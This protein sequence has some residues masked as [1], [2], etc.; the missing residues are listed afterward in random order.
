MKILF[1]GLGSIG[2]RHLRLIQQHFP[3]METWAHRTHLGQNSFEDPDI[4]LVF[5]W[6]GIDYL[7]PDIAFI[8]NPP[9]LHISTAIKCAKRGMHLFIEKP[10]GHNTDG[11]D[12]LLK[13]CDQ[14]GLTAYVAYPLRFHPT[15]QHLQAIVENN[16]PL[17]ARI[18]CTS[19]L[20]GWRPGRNHLESYSA[21]ENMGGGALLDVSHEIYYAEW[22]FG[23][24][25]EIQGTRGRVAD[26]ITIDTDDFCD[27]TIVHD[28]GF[29]S[30]VYISLLSKK[31]RRHCTIECREGRFKDYFNFEPAVSEKM[32]VDQLH[33]FFNNIDNPELAGNLA[34]CAP[35]FRQIIK[36][37]QEGLR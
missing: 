29:V 32:F 11:L 28:G 30:H 18:I 37:R 8:C 10:I 35:L 15:F 13:I 7:N 21:I 25:F 16:T 9:Y 31:L 36:F 27:L 1:F 17:H 26:N 20:P 6:N 12:T 3:N 23:P 22:L 34:E 5:D 2:Q 24:V 4:G 33:H 19:Y 14:K